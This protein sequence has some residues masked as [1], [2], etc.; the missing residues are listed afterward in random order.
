[1][2]EELLS[3]PNGTTEASRELAPLKSNAS[4]PQAATVVLLLL[5]VAWQTLLIHSTAMIIPSVRR[6]YVLPPSRL[7]ARLS[8]PPTHTRSWRSRQKQSQQ[9]QGP[10]LHM[11]SSKRH[12]SWVREQGRRVSEGAGSV[13]EDSSQTQEEG[14]RGGYLNKEGSASTLEECSSWE[15]S[16]SDLAPSP[17][18]PLALPPSPAGSP[19]SLP[20]AVMRWLLSAPG[21]VPGGAG[22]TKHRVEAAGDRSEGAATKHAVW[23][24]ATLESDGK[25]PQRHAAWLQEQS[26]LARKVADTEDSAAHTRNP[27]HPPPTHPHPHTPHTELPTPQSHSQHVTLQAE[28][29]RRVWFHPTHP[30]SPR[31]HS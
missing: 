2:V 21:G 15:T 12:L 24:R 9:S 10:L 16:R 4:T 29:H 6:T 13:R 31:P 14:S 26:E 22:S 25:Q 11:A 28:G 20:K 7:S 19:C 17:A 23:L 1:M 5:D 18:L 3:P 27:H 30:P 8:A